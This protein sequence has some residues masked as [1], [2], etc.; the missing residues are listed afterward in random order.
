MEKIFCFETTQFDLDFINHIKKIRKGEELT[1]DELSLKMGV[2][3]SFVSNVESFTQRHKYSTRHIALLA[4]AFGYKNI[5]DLMKFPTPQYDKI[6]V[7]VKQIMNESGTKALRAEVL[8]I[9]PLK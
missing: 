9:E 6:K 8:K 7:T 3:K 2:A 5:A 1:K 4:Q